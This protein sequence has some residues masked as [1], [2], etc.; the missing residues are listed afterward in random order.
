MSLHPSLSLTRIGGSS[1][2]LSTAASGNNCWIGGLEPGANHRARGRSHPNCSGGKLMQ[3]RS[4]NGISLSF[5][6]LNCI[7]ITTLN[8][9]LKNISKF[10]MII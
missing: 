4:N 9:I 10:N 1:M 3:A 5:N 6:C 7:G 2:T 8:K